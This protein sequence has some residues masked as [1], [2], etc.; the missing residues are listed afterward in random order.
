M[1]GVQTCALPICCRYE[2]TAADIIRPEDWEQQR[3]PLYYVTARYIR[4]I[5]T[6]VR[7]CPSQYLWMHRRWKSR[8]RFEREGQPMP[9][10]LQRNLEELPWMDQATMKDLVRGG[11][12]EQPG[13]E[14]SPVAR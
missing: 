13:A 5:E 3:D 7:A 12:I 11:R 4:A 8:P 9:P 6:M 2:L 1:T 10:G 14:C